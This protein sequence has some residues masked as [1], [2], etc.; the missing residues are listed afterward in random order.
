MNELAAKIAD[1]T[2]VIDPWPHVIIDD[3]LPGD[4]FAE[5]VAWLP[6]IG[7]GPPDC[8]KF[9]D[10]PARLRGALTD[11]DLETT[12]RQRFG[13]EK[14]EPSIEMV[15][16]RS[17]LKPH[18]D[19]QDKPWS[20]L[21]YVAGDSVGT[22]LY[23]ATGRLAKSVEWKPNRLVCWARRPRKEEHAVPVSKGR[24]VLVWW[25]L[26]TLAAKG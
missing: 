19:R 15:Y 11:A 25:F 21:I 23:D 16:R 2:E 10:I 13:F 22:D 3:F 5:L 26:K 12:I 24:Y 20:G 17:G 9:K 4:L 1:A 14:C 6:E 7:D 18:A 8:R